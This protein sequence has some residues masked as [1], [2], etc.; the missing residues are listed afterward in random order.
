MSVMII[1]KAAKKV[2]NV[3]CIVIMVIVIQRSC[4]IMWGTISRS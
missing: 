3:C 2:T 1:R 4:S